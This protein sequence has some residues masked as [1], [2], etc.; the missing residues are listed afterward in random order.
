[1]C[2]KGLLVKMAAEWR[3][4][5]QYLLPEKHERKGDGFEVWPSY[6]CKSVISSGY[7]P[8][9]KE[10]RASG[11]TIILVDGYSGVFWAECRSELLVGGGGSSN[12]VHEHMED[13]M[14]DEEEIR[15]MYYPFL[16]AGDP[17]FGFRTTLDLPDLF[18]RLG[19]LEQ[20]VS[21]SEGIIIISGVGAG[22]LRHIRPEETLLVYL[23]VPKNEIQYRSRAETIS[24]L[25]IRRCFHKKV[26]YKHYYFIEWPMLNRYRAELIKDIDIFV[27]SQRKGCPLFTSG[28]GIRKT[29][30]E[31]AQN[32][33]RCRPWFEPGVWGG[34][35]LK[36]R[37]DTLP[38]N[39][40]NY[41]WSFEAIVWENGLIFE[42]NGYMLELSFDFLMFQEYKNVL[43]NFANR[44]GYE[45]PIR[46]DYLDTV[47]GQNL[48][49]Q[50][51]PRPE[52]IINNFGENF[53]QD[54]TY[55]M[56]HS[57]S[58]A[59][60]YC[61]FQDDINPEEFEAALR[62]AEKTGEKLDADKFVASIPVKTHDLILIPNGTPHCSGAGSVVLEISST[63]YIFTFKMYDWQRLDLDG[64]PRPINI[65]RAMQNLRWHRRPKDLK[66]KPTQISKNVEHM[67][68][69]KDHFYDVTRYT[70]QAQESITVHTKGSA[71]VL[72]VVEGSKILVSTKDRLDIP[73]MGL[74]TFL[75]PS[76]AGSYTLRNPVD[77][78]VK[79]IC[80]YMKPEED[81]CCVISL[82]VGGTSVKSAVIT[83][84]K[85]VTHFE[86]DAID[87]FGS[88]EDI[89][90]TLHNI[91]QTHLRKLDPA[92][93]YH[94]ALG[95]PGPCDYEAGICKIES[96]LMKFESL[97]GV[98]V[99][100]ELD[101][102]L[103]SKRPLSITFENDASAAIF[104]EMMTGSA[105]ECSRVLGVTL[106]TGF[107]SCYI[108][109]GKIV[110]SGKGVPENGWLYPIEFDGLPADDV[111]SIRGLEA[112]LTAEGMEWEN[113]QSLDQNDKYMKP[114]LSQWAKDLRKFLKH[115][116]EAFEADAILLTGGLSILFQT[117]LR[118]AFSSE[119]MGLKVFF[120]E[121][122]EIQS[123][124][125]VGLAIQS[126][127]RY[128]RKIQPSAG[129]SASPFS[130]WKI[131]LVLTF[132][133]SV[134]FGF[135]SYFQ[136]QPRK[137]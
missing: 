12:V 84:D 102:R 53:T 26:M 45:Y 110:T 81:T 6:P 136:R 91:I 10:I 104:G 117:F 127:S 98:N 28:V 129:G 60:A 70:L 76:A 4:T 137:R 135:L 1:V 72:N 16:G 126:W 90:E 33:H 78:T 111:F 65:D 73:Y 62:H 58:G 50:C 52:F 106:G 121:N 21:K 22:L 80:S 8:L 17:I 128:K 59:V 133:A 67:P 61:G 75:I 74:E 54:E 14:Y 85:C 9:N 68:T 23:D 38:Q 119:E 36:E 105:K 97:F 83:P 96:S 42:E 51:H 5:T 88:K 39:V 43:G 20:K 123:S 40:P 118:D 108:V 86:V 35:F 13:Y 103:S 77:H 107:G 99:I 131:I 57:E 63:P 130:Y 125:L 29:I 109:D 7:G 115:H 132:F 113:L 69:H 114:I 48:S 112:R 47:K 55:Y 44:F 100:N 116:A 34:Q 64:K 49:L 134:F 37:I 3:K 66:S 19:A 27:D 124:A 2:E 82:D 24:N 46:F 31:M 122:R 101:S 87:A 92:V 41:A 79:V 95:F 25:G 30:E 94:L 93:G 32:V 71:H 18:S 89:L 15:R 56:T 11:K 120:A